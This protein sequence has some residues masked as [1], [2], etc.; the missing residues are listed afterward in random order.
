[1]VMYPIVVVPI[2]NDAGRKREASMRYQTL[3]PIP[4][5]AGFD[6]ARFGENSIIPSSKFCR[7]LRAQYMLAYY[8]RI[9]PANTPK[10]HSV[11]VEL[12]RKDLR[13]Q[14]RAGYYGEDSR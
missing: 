1:V 13:A 11:R 6:A 2:E 7:D 3:P 12:Q 4:A 9:L 10:F 5:A 8:R 14:T